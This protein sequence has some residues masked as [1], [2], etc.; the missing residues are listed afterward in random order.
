M[1]ESLEICTDG[2]DTFA[3]SSFTTVYYAR[4]HDLAAV[5]DGAQKGDQ[6]WWWNT[7]RIDGKAWRPEVDA[8]ASEVT[9]KQLLRK[10]YSDR[11]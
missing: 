11:Y 6:R 9:C 10:E 8:S 1:P 4:G 7:D 3:Q 2:T 5:V